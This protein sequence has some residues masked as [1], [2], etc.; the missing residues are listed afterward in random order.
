MWANAV[1]RTGEDVFNQTADQIGER[2]D[3][4]RARVIAQAECRRRL[5]AKRKEWLDEQ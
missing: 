4:L 3:A 2:A 1:V 5:Y